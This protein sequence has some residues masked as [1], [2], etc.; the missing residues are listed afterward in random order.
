MLKRYI[1]VNEK[2]GTLAFAGRRF[3]TATGAA[4]YA[5]RRFSHTV[6]SM[7]NISVMRIEKPL[8]FLKLA[9]EH[10]YYRRHRES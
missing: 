7:F 2:F 6:I 3:F 4:L 5:R 1:I 9:R 10:G 8:E